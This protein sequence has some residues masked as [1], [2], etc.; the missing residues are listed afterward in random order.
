MVRTVEAKRNDPELPR[1]CEGVLTFHDRVDDGEVE[2]FLDSSLTWLLELYEGG[3]V[4]PCGI[5]AD[6]LDGG[7]L[8][9]YGRM[10]LGPRR[11]IIPGRVTLSQYLKRAAPG[12]NALPEDDRRLIRFVVSA[13][14]ETQG[15]PLE[16]SISV[17]AFTLE[18]LAIVWLPATA[19]EFGLPDAKVRKQIRDEIRRAVDELAPQSELAV[20]LDQMFSHLFSRPAAGRIERLLQMLDIP[21][22]S[23]DL[24]NFVRCRNN[25]THAGSKDERDDRVRAMMWGH[26]AIARCALARLGY[27]GEVYDELAREV[28]VR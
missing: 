26:Q 13:R 23:E 17:A 6:E 2:E 9:D 1:L 20:R 18:L 27:D 25:I 3:E 22:E 4:V 28:S 11:R 8:T 10:L 5:W 14:K 19:K 21:F 15:A 16:M 24:D 12:W 7:R